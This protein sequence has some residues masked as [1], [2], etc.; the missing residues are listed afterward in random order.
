MK[1]ILL[2]LLVAATAGGSVGVLVVHV[3]PGLEVFVDGASAGLST[4]EEGG[5]VIK[6]I[7]PGPH[8]V[9]VKAPDGRQASFN[10]NVT[11]GQTSE[12][13][14]SPLGFRKLA[15]PQTPD[16]S[17][18]LRVTSLPPDSQIVVNGVTRL[19]SD[20]SEITFDS[21]PA[22]KQPI[23]IT[24]AGRSH[25]G[26]VE[27]AKGSA[28]TV[29]FDARSGAYK[30]TESKPRPRRLQLAEP[31]DAL[32]RLGIPSH[33]RSA[34]R[35]ALPSTVSIVD[36]GASGNRVLV[37]LN[38][39]SERVANALLTSLVRSRDFIRVNYASNP[40]RE[41]NGWVVDFAFYFP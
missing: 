12:A 32:T 36:A 27:V 41:Q 2:A 5:R 13:T 3:T 21:V 1:S 4:P 19:N 16:E 20:A 10:V 6:G 22:G 18:S 34:I 37:T 17:S 9:V 24:T 25:S 31:N 39:P 28:I 26:F 15:T 11:A 23:V 7:V 35:T 33:W 14:V 40:R 38:V 8:H 29:N 30:V